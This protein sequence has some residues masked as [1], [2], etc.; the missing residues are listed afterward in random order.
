[1]E[2]DVKLAIARR[3][4]GTALA[5]F[6]NDDDP[7]SVHSL[8]CSGS[9]IAGVLAQDADE[10]P[11]RDHVLAVHPDM[12]VKQIEG[13]RK[14][15]WNA[16]KH[17][18]RHDG[19]SRNDEEL[20][21]EFND[22]QNDHALFWGWYDF[23]NAATCLPLEAQVFQVWYFARYPDKL[24]PDHDSGA[25]RRLFPD[26]DKLPRNVAKDRMRKVIARYKKDR[27]IMDDPRT[28]RR[29]LILNRLAAP[30]PGAR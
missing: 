20:L 18:T 7:V 17:A 6:L 15:T 8:A 12:T 2:N 4:L 3:Q 24:A 19:K 14:R 23:A 9:E 21:A 5:L 22:E 28:D 25:Y 30:L 1:M 29:L 27:T 11:F 10:M 13:L 26:L 16:L